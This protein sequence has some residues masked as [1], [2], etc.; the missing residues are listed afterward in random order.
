MK[1]KQPLNEGGKFH[2]SALVQQVRSLGINGFLELC[3]MSILE[4]AF[5]ASRQICVGF[6]V[7]TNCYS[8]FQFYFES[9]SMNRFSNSQG[10]DHNLCSVFIVRNWGEREQ[11]GVFIDLLFTQ[12]YDDEQADYQD[13]KTILIVT[14]I[15][16]QNTSSTEQHI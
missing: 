15:G 2:S 8:E 7:K 11:Y 1:S 5:S 13:I 14:G 12:F 9:D 3:P 4:N 16:L 10:K 6:Q